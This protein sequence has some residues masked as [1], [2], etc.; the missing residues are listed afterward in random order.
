MVDLSVTYTATRG[1][2]AGHLLNSLQTFEIDL[3]RLDPTDKIKATQVLTPT[4]AETELVSLVTEYR[5]E[6]K[7]MDNAL[8][9]LCREFLLSCMASETF[10]V[11]LFGAAG[12]NAQLILNRNLVPEN[13]FPLKYRYQFKMRVY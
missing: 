13:P 5:V 6:T 4:D 12:Q 9:L 8:M 11:S 7:L 2:A 3:I 10:T 1:L